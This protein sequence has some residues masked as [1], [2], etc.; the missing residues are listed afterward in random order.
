MIKYHLTQPY[1]EP[2]RENEPWWLVQV[3]AIDDVDLVAYLKI[4]WIDH[5]TA[6]QHYELAQ[7]RL[8]DPYFWRFLK[9]RAGWVYVD[10]SRVSHD[11]RRQGIATQ[12]YRIGAAWAASK[13]KTC[14]HGSSIQSS[15]AKALWESFTETDL[16]LIEKQ[17]PRKPDK[18]Y[19]AIDYSSS[20]KL[21]L[22]AQRIL[23]NIPVL[24]APWDQNNFK[25]TDPYRLK[26]VATE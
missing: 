9:E 10:F 25:N 5:A 21:R 3:Q 7:S 11:Y 20:L 15:E 2:G 14:L 1:Q 26:L 4:C 8:R 19:Q 13:L 6:C 16:P 17:S 24:D 12:M 18:Q 22:Q 23:T